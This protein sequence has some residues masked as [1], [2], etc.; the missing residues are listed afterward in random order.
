MIATYGIPE[1]LEAKF[2]RAPTSK[3]KPI[4]PDSLSEL[5]VIGGNKW[6]IPIEMLGLWDTV[7]AFGMP[8][9]HFEPFRTL[10]I[11]EN[12]NKVYHLVAIDERRWAFDAT[13]IDHD[14]KVEEV[15]FPGAHSN[16]G[17]GSGDNGL[18]NVA[19]Q[20]MIAR[21]QKNHDLVFT[22]EIKKEMFVGNA[23]AKI[24]SLLLPWVHWQIPQFHRRKIQ[25]QGKEP[26]PLP[27]IHKSVLERMGSPGEHAPYAPPNL[28]SPLEAGKAY[29]LVNGS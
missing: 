6:P 16:V 22:A 24:W 5:A 21:A 23:K 8:F 10:S 11:P 18:S 12:V 4:E 26:L 25:V 28:K 14:P 15:W 17:G 13:L 3:G 2:K 7:A 19:L 9:N 29:E 1:R 20:F 27:R